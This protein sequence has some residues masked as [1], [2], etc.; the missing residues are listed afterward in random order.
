MGETKE[1]SPLIF[2]DVVKVHQDNGGDDCLSLAF[3]ELANVVH[4]GYRIAKKHLKLSNCDLVVSTLQDTSSEGNHTGKI[5]WE[6][7]Y[8]LMDFLLERGVT[9]GKVLEVGAGCGMLGQVLAASKYTK[10]V[11]LTECDE[12]MRNV[13][14]NL[15]RNQGIFRS[16]KDQPR[17]VARQLDWLDPKRDIAIASKDLRK[18]S[19][20]TIVGTDVVYTPS[21]V[22]P[23]LTTLR[24]MAHE[25]TIV[26]LCL[27]IRCEDS[28]QLLLRK[29]STFNWKVDD[30]SQEL[31]NMLSCSWGLDMECKLLQLTTIN[32]T[33]TKKRSTTSGSKTEEVLV[34]VQQTKRV[35]R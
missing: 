31:K 10:K 34:E 15:D 28:H 27:Q 1:R 2:Q 17:V 13:Q 3:F 24:L 33:V 5:V 20:D 19:F 9:L 26:Y 18:H 32:R 8:L 12:V 29:A 11:V 35:K 21:L 14:R 4:V 23:L 25:R 16:K 30:I 7:S 22:E 6:T